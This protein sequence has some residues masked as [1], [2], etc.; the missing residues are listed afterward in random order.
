MSGA[1]FRGLSESVAGVQGAPHVS[2]GL[3]VTG[4]QSV[5]VA[6]QTLFVTADV[7]LTRCRVY[8]LDLEI[9][10]EMEEALQVHVH[11]LSD[12]AGIGVPAP[13]TFH[14]SHRKRV[15]GS[16]DANRGSRIEVGDACA[17]PHQICGP[18]W[19]GHLIEIAVENNRRHVNS[20]LIELRHFQMMLGYLSKVSL[21]KMCVGLRMSAIV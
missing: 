19:K 7:A 3:F 9:T 15:D 20:L 11:I 16:R 18:Y 17:S 21:R 12:R 13:Y 6:R 2:Q 10:G 8:D 14:Q 4:G 5:D 1:E